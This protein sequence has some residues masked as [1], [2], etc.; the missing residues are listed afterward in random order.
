MQNSIFANA[1]K[2]LTLSLKEIRSAAIEKSPDA[3]SLTEIRHLSP[4]EY[5]VVAG[6]PEVENEPHK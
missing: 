3:T 1:K 2:A 4:R 5:S 6:G